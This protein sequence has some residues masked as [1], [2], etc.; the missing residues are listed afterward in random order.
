[1]QRPEVQWQLA[2][3]VAHVRLLHPDP[4]SSSI[5]ETR[6]FPAQ[7]PASYYCQFPLIAHVAAA[8]DAIR[9]NAFGKNAFVALNPRD[10]H[11]GRKI[12][13]P[14][15][16]WILLDLDSEKLVVEDVINKFA[17]HGILPS[18][19]IVSGHGLHFYIRLWP[20]VAPGVA[21][22]AVG[23]RLNIATGGDHVFDCCRVARLAGSVNHKTPPTIAYIAGIW[24]ERWYS[25]ETLDRAADSMK[26]P[27]FSVERPG[28]AP[29]EPASY[30]FLSPPP[31]SSE[32]PPDLM[33]ILTALPSNVAQVIRT[34][35]RP[36]HYVKSGN[37]EL[38]FQVMCEL[39]RAGLSDAEIV[40][41]YSFTPVR[42]LK[43]DRARQ[44]YFPRTLAAA[45]RDVENHRQRT[46][47]ILDLPAAQTETTPEPPDRRVAKI[48]A[49]FPNWDESVSLPKPP[50]N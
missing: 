18:A 11:R 37:S 28:T 2:H 3:A 22:E 49:P 30:G 41:V 39:V 32:T 20:P 27:R 24:P 31:A 36:A 34:G 50:R 4:N 29:T 48:R 7:K 9:A 1:M 13:V 15:A 14:A 10:K 19:L 25:V 26:V 42:R 23:R 40:R 5:I 8:E 44:D 16:N 43:V 17:D 33:E 6:I 21:A 46:P 12:D 35:E 47:S 38:D 45:K